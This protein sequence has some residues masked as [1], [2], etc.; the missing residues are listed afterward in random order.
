MQFYI[1]AV[2]KIIEVV[3]VSTIVFAT[4]ISFIKYLFS[5]Q[6]MVP[7]SYKQ[8]RQDLGKG[9]LLGLEV[10]VAG[11]IIATVVTEPTMDRVLALGVI[12]LIR[13]LLSFS[14]QVEID[15]KLPW[16]Q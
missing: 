15:G 3:G 12:V 2:A 16:S 7:R 1:G 10:L 8:L 5:I 9:I 4:A 6:G 11:D 13:T 14:L